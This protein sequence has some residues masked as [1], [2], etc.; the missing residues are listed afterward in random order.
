M[1][2]KKTSVRNMFYKQFLQLQD[3]LT[4]V[5]KGCEMGVRR[6]EKESSKG[7]FQ[8]FC[9]T[10]YRIAVQAY[11]FKN[12]FGTRFNIPLKALWLH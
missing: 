8:L 12:K 9:K 4:F 3:G 5:P 10:V 7:R 2:E 11:L 6:F 1:F